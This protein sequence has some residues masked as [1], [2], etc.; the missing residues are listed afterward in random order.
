MIRDAEVPAEQEMNYLR[1][2]T[3]GEVQKVVDNFRKRRCGDPAAVL[4]DIWKE[5]EKRFGNVAAIT[6]TLLERLSA[7]ARFEE[8]YKASKYKQEKYK[9]SQIFSLMWTDSRE[10]SHPPTL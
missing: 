1:S 3:K 4:E 10:T 2:Y 5:L 7:S 9:P 8:K 6:N